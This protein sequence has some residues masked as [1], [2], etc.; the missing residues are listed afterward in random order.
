MKLTSFLIVVL[1]Y[2]GVYGQNN[3]DA[4]KHLGAGIVIG[5]VG[6]YTAH[7]L[8]N[9]Q[10]GWTWAGAL[11]SSLAAGL[12]KEALYDQPRGT[13]WESRDVLFTALGGLVSGLALDLLLKNSRRRG[14]GGKKRNCGCLV[15]T[16][17]GPS[18][19]PSALYFEN[20]SR[21]ITSALEASYLLK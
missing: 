11:G 4:V 17:I 21:D 7:K 18:T 16:V 1:L 8:F 20:G 2:S 14:G 12:A 5:G 6:G 15:A 10:R 3:A 19:D 9:G 13:E